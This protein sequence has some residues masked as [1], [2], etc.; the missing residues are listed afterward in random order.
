VL[1][2]PSRWKVTR[3]RK[4]RFPY[5]S[6]TTEVMNGKVF[7]AIKTGSTLYESPAGENGCSLAR[8]I[9]PSNS[10]TIDSGTLISTFSGHLGQVQCI[11][12]V[13]S[14]MLEAQTTTED[15][16]RKH[17]L[18]C[19]L[20]NTIKLWHVPTADLREDSFW[21]CGGGVG[22]RSGFASL[23]SVAQD[24]LIKVWDVEGEK[25]EHNLVGHGSP[26]T[27]VAVKR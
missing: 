20:D 22:D 26:V 9:P 14:P 21:T 19:S 1:C 15:G 4:C 2:L 13:P 3:F 12:P 18:S 27:C 10:G 11:I 6:G 8:M 17:I 24:R 25:C 16:L 5:E 7:G 23:I